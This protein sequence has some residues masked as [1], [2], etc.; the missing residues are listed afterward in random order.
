MLTHI[1]S[2]IRTISFRAV[3]LISVPLHMII[4]VGMLNYERKNEIMNLKEFGPK[5]L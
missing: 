3:C 4:S 1:S 2:Q 5:L